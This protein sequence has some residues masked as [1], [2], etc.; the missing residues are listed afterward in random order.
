MY[1]LFVIRCTATNKHHSKI[2]IIKK[3]IKAC[4]Q[5]KFFLNIFLCFSFFGNS[6][7]KIMIDFLLISF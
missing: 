5:Q 1:K 6:Y 3:I 4:R 2:T 7:V